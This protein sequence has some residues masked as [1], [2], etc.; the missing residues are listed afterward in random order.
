ML[1]SQLQRIKALKAV[2]E[3]NR[4]ISCYYYIAKITLENYNMLVGFKKTDEF[5]L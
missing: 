1:S 5:L 4:G 2:Y 3:F